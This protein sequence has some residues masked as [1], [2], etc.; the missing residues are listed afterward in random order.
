MNDG[1]LAKETNYNND[2]SW[3]SIKEIP[4]PPT[5]EKSWADEVEDKKKA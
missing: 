3:G 2:D 1:E 4:F 5:Q